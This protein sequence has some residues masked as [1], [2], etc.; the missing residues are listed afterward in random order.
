[1]RV[2]FLNQ[3]EKID[4]FSF[5]NHAALHLTV[6]YFAA[7]EPS[8]SPRRCL[9]QSAKNG[10]RSCRMEFWFESSPWRQRSPKGVKGVPRAVELWFYLRRVFLIY[11]LYKRLTRGSS[12]W[13]FLMPVRCHSQRSLHVFMSATPSKLG[14]TNTFISNQTDVWEFSA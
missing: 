13:S 12:R 1:M 11:L 2:L 3:K 4:L 8:D 6:V 10:I 7:T 14:N 9:L 5:C